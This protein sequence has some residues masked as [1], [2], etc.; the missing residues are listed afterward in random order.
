MWIDKPS[1][2]QCHGEP[3]GMTPSGVGAVRDVTIALA[4]QSR[5]NLA[6]VQSLDRQ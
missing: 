5:T 1:M 2:E 3:A 6:E 4:E